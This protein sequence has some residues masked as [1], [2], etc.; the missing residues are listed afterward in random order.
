M[1]EETEVE[2]TIVWGL[3]PLVQIA[4]LSEEE[5]RKMSCIAGN[6][7]SK[8]DPDVVEHDFKKFFT[9]INPPMHWP[10]RR[11]WLCAI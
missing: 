4:M 1:A 3:S 8:V 7:R 11:V 10:V 2:E 6:L 5:H 9:V